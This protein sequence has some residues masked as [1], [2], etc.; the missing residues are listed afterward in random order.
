MII[1]KIKNIP[2]L[3]VPPTRLTPLSS[4]VMHRHPMPLVPD[5]GPTHMS[6]V[7]MSVDWA[8]GDILGDMV[9]R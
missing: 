9:G 5:R 7:D 4:D 8:V 2:E 6:L 1:L 3:Y